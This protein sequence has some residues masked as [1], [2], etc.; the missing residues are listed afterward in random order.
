MLPQAWSV[1]SGAAPRARCEQ[2]MDAAQRELVLPEGGLIRL[3]TPPFDRTAARPGYIK[4][5]VPGIRENGGQYTHA[6]L[7]AVRAGAELGWRERAL[8]LLEMLL[9]VNHARTPE[10]VATYQVEPYVVA[11]DVYAVP[12]HV[13]RGGWT[14]YTGSS[15]W[16]L[17]VALESVLGLRIEEGR[18]LRAA[19]LRARRL[20]GLPHRVP[21]AGRRHALRDR[22]AEPGAAA[23]RA[24]CASRLDGAP[25]APEDGAAVWPI[26]R[27]GARHEVEVE[28]G[29]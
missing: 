20:A 18:R 22:G 1:L 2:A 17:R 9:P 19:P 27:D 29:A 12:P 8:A 26:A 3:L 11:A 28:L 7:W 5:Y 24:W 6:A 21:R 23:A 10:E 14:W 25:L 13:G 4:G 16:M 15:G